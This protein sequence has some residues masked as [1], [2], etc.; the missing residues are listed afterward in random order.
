MCCDKST[1][2]TM[3]SSTAV[4][5]VSSVQMLA[6]LGKS[7]HTVIPLELQIQLLEDWN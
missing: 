1:Y 5:Y 2:F 6:P 3:D 4:Q 7:D